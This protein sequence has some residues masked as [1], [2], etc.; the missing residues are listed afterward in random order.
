[1]TGSERLGA[2]A[3]IAALALLTIAAI[4]HH[5]LTTSAPVSPVARPQGA[6]IHMQSD[7]AG[8]SGA[9]AARPTTVA[10]PVSCEKLPHVP[11]K[12]ITTMVVEFPP[13]A[14]SPA[15]RHPGSVTAYVLKGK[16]RSQLGGGPAI[17]YKTGETWFEPPGTLH[18]FAENP[19]ATEPAALLATFVAEDDCGPLTVYEK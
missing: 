4:G 14:Y 17:T 3:G 2:A 5:L 19:S 6:H 15:H 18:Q 12:S 10:K 11:G 13:N 16:V 7:A 9:A 1:M 8:G